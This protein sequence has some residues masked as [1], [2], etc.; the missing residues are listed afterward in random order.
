M[1]HRHILS[2][3][4]TLTNKNL[5]VFHPPIAGAHTNVYELDGNTGLCTCI[6]EMLLQSHDGELHLLP[7]LPQ[8]WSEGS[9]KG[10]RARGGFGVDLTW[11]NSAL[12]E[13]HIYSLVGGAC[14]VRYRSELTITLNG[15]T[16]PGQLSKPSIII[17]ETMKDERYILIPK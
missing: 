17:F 15:E 8:A 4:C 3:Q 2:M 5:F 9:V 16:I 6:A 12:T 14:Q 11:K 1:V 7:A 10:L 13:A